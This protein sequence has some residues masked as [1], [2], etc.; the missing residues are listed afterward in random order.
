MGG[1]EAVHHLSYYH[2]GDEQG[3][4]IDSRQN[5]RDAVLSDPKVNGQ[6]DGQH[7]R[8]C[9]IEEGDRKGEGNVFRIQINRFKVIFEGKGTAFIEETT[10]D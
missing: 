3:Q 10:N 4:F 9:G 2:E 8:A 1:E 6:K 7:C 5:L